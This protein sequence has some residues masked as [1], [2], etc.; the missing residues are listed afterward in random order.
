MIFVLSFCNFRMP[1]RIKPGPKASPGRRGGF[2]RKGGEPVVYVT[3]SLPEKN[4][5]K[6]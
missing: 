1:G 3:V 6:L 5:K 2:A 4:D